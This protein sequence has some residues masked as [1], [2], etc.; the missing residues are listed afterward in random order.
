MNYPST[1]ISPIPKWLCNIVSIAMMY[2]VFG[3]QMQA[4]P[5]DW[6]VYESHV[7][8]I[9]EL[10]PPLPCFGSVQISVAQNGKA[11]LTP[12]MFISDPAFPVNAM[13][14]IV[15]ETNRNFV[16]CGDIGKNRSAKITDTITNNSC[17]VVLKVED[18][19]FP[20]LVCVSDT[21]ECTT[22][23]FSVNY[24]SLITVIDNCDPNP[25]VRYGLQFQ[26]L[27]CDVR[28]SS[29]MYVNYIVT[30]VSGNSSSCSKEVYFRKVPLDSIQFPPNDTLYCNLIGD[31][32]VPEYKGEPINI[33]CDLIS[34]FRDDTIRVCGGMY[35]II[36]NWTVMDWCLRTSINRQQEILVADTS[37]PNIQCLSDTTIINRSQSCTVTYK[38]PKFDANDA[39]SPKELLY[40]VV[41]IDSSYI[42][43]P[44]S[45]VNLDE[46]VHT[47][48]YIV[49]D[50]CGNGDTCSRKITVVDRS[51]PS[52]VCPSKLIVSLGVNGEVKIDIHYLEKFV[53]YNDNC[54]IED[55]L[56][57]RMTSRCAHPEDTLFRHDVNFCC[58]DVGLTEM[59]VVQVSDNSGNV[60]FCMIPIEVQNKLASS[61]VCP[62]NVTLDCDQDPLDTTLT[63]FP[64]V[65]N[66]CT[67]FT[68]QISYTDSNSVD[69]CNVG[70]I[71]RKFYITLA[72]G[73]IDS[74]CRQNIT[75]INRVAT[76]DI[77]WPRDTTIEACTPSHP[78]SIESVP[79]V[80]NYFCS[81]IFFNYRDSVPNLP[82]DSCPRIIR[83]WNSNPSCGFGIY[84]DTQTILLIDLNPPK[85]IGPK[86]TFHCVEDTFCHPLII[87]PALSITGCNNIISVSNNIT[88]GG[89][90]CSGIYSLGRHV[91]IFTVVDACNHTVYDTVIIDVVDKI[92][93]VIGC[94][95]IARNIEINDS[96]K[97]IARDLLL[98]NY[99]DNCTS[100]DELIISFDPNNPN[101][102]CRFISCSKHKQF[103]DSLWP[104]VVFVK[105][106]SDNTAFCTGRLNVD[107]PNGFCNNLTGKKINV[108]GLIR[109]TSKAPMVNISINE[110]I[111]HRES[112]TNYLGTFE[113]EELSIGSNAEF[114]PAYNTDWLE[115]ISTLDIIRIQKH[116]LGVDLL[117]SPYEW[118][119]ADVNMDGKVT[120]LDVSLLRKLILGLTDSIPGSSSFRFIPEA[121]QFKNTDYPLNDQI[122]NGI[123]TQELNSEFKPN[124]YGIKVGD[125]SDA[126][127]TTE[128]SVISRN[129]Y[130]S[131]STEDITMVPDL[132]IIGVFS[133]D[134]DFTVEGFQL[135]IQFNP[136]LG[137][138]E[139]VIEYGTLSTGL[140][141][142]ED[143]YAVIGDE[144]V[145]SYNNKFPKRVL[146]SDKL[147]GIVWKVNEVCKMSQLINET[148]YKENEV[149]ISGYNSYPLIMRIKY[150]NLQEISPS[151]ENFKLAPNPFS[152]DCTLSFISN[153]EIEANLDVI[154]NDGKRY[155][156]KWI[157]LVKGYNNITINRNE[158]GAQGIYHYKF[159]VGDNLKKGK[160]VLAK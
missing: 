89:A 143:Q 71:F 93:P 14:V 7:E 112:R 69:S 85:L 155:I 23:P 136:E 91:V 90:D 49:L 101:D 150:T 51:S 3:I 127:G 27:N 78:D 46:G 148:A 19:L 94:R 76:L 66:L 62:T 47:L 153:S 63:G 55:I 73:V 79:V 54:G 75:L 24:D 20:T 70:V 99:S 87:L 29:I 50:P 156:S 128:N 82:N 142:P 118:L 135:R 11:V 32:G 12:K 103:P 60:N 30:D 61:I 113:I 31:S 52:L 77:E 110:M 48:D 4:S 5:E 134:Q 15:L 45:S 157:P 154:S 16:D 64:I 28:F 21:F 25:E 147:F 18:K 41:R 9:Y 95:S 107:D 74:S 141:I 42:T 111:A 81:H 122:P 102:T 96:A 138:P 104:F 117:R 43:V 133:A 144:I 137:Y 116:I 80:L 149:F 92:A 40:Y 83:M 130:Y 152:Q 39:C 1:Q 2:V 129:R 84:R 38:L 109:K 131:I 37:R 146:K 140:A 132:N 57:R 145:I 36:R 56:I 58:Y 105:D 13:K 22:D 124:F 98:I 120:S 123:F 59:L 72:N 151:I 86:D 114:I 97:V 35:K 119:A 125:V 160:L 44:G 108:T 34:T 100:K 106:L 17:W 159:I 88:N 68:T 121:Y 139:R 53:Y 8:Q 67:N 158:L 10:L 126:K 26:K 33:V 6:P 65:N 115:G